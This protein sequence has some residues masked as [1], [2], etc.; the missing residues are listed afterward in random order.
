MVRRENGVWNTT[1]N[2]LLIYRLHDAFHLQRIATEPDVVD[3]THNTVD[4]E[5]TRQRLLSLK[6]DN[7]KDPIVRNIN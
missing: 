2:I 3:A 4:M 5:T 7:Y 6:K 1:L